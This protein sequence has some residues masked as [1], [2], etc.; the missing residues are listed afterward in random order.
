[1]KDELGLSLSG[2]SVSGFIPS[3]LWWLVPISVLGDL[4]IG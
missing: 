2:F 3:S 4:P 1:M